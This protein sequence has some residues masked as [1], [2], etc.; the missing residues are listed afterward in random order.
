MVQIEGIMS[1]DKSESTGFWSGKVV[2]TILEILVLFVIGAVLGAGIGA[3]YCIT[4]QDFS[5]FFYFVI[6]VPIILIL[7]VYI[8]SF[9]EKHLTTYRKNGARPPFYKDSTV[10]GEVIDW[11]MMVT[12]M[13]VA[14]LPRG[15]YWLVPLGILFTTVVI[16]I[17]CLVD[18]RKFWKKADRSGGSGVPGGGK[19]SEGKAGSSGDGEDSSDGDIDE[20][21]IQMPYYTPEIWM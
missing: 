3:I 19:S 13:T 16:G 6:G 4:M 21:E 2:T 10:L 7:H 1:Q 11:G 5:S 8:W 15:R 12:F 14:T 18:R 20:D 9:L 17:G